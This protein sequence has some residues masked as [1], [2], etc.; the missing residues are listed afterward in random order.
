MRGLL[1][2]EF[3]VICSKNDL[4]VRVGKSEPMERAKVRLHRLAHVIVY[5][6]PCH[7]QG[8]IRVVECGVTS[9]DEPKNASVC[10]ELCKVSGNLGMQSWKTCG[11]SNKWL[12]D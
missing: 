2:H 5:Y 7:Y 8:N 12:N 10:L 11:G 3:K 1:L 4:S 6:R 9:F